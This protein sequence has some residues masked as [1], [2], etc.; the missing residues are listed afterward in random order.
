DRV[1]VED[2]DRLLDFAL[3]RG[4]V[5]PLFHED[6]DDVIHVTFD[7]RGGVAGYGIARELGPGDERVSTDLVDMFEALAEQLRPRYGWSVDQRRFEEHA[8]AWEAHVAAIRAG[9]AP[10]YFYWLN[11]FSAEYFARVEPLLDGVPHMRRR[12]GE[13]AV[14]QLAADPWDGRVLYV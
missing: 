5:V 4:G 10:H 9:A 8:A 11:Y 6:V 1:E 3:E 13:G 12:I 2:R 7:A 14:V